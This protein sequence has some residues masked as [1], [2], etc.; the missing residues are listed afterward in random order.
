MSE[1][2]N[3]EKNFKFSVADPLSLD[4][5]ASRSRPRSID[6]LLDRLPDPPGAN[7]ISELTSNASRSSSVS[8]QIRQFRQYYSNSDDS[9]SPSI[10]S[11]YFPETMA[12]GQV[13]E[14]GVAPQMDFIQATQHGYRKFLI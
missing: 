4:A 5:A 2:I 7:E 1:Y 11:G 14:S 6:D 13:V 12:D 3:F 9:E 10:N 8:S